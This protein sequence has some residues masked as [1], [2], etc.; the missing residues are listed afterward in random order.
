M[1]D[2]SKVVCVIETVAR[3]EITI[4]NLTEKQ[5]ASIEDEEAAFEEFVKP[6]LS[7]LSDKLVDGGAKRVILHTVCG[8]LLDG[9]SLHKNGD[10]DRDEY[11]FDPEELE[12]EDEDEDEEDD[13]EEDE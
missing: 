1:G 4:P 10:V 7:R 11:A 5:L 3:Y 12:D 2:N 8:G 13:E 9:I 6:Q